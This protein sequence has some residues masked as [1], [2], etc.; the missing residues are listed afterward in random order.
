MDILEDAQA[1]ARL[2]PDAIER[3]TRSATDSTFYVE[4]LSDA[5][6][7]ANRRIVA[8]S[9]AACETAAANAQQAFF[10]AFI[11]ERFAG[12]VIAT[13]HGDDDLE[14][15]WLMVDPDFHGTPVSKALMRRGVAWLGADRPM[16]LN[17]I[18]FNRRAIRFYERFGFVVDPD[19]RTQHVVPHLIMRRKPAAL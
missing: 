4:P 19:A 5:Q 9:K 13:R 2:A 7:A 3:L 17:V 10:A 11:A 6:I 18:A 15:D 12:Y 1:L 8:I 16:W 14:L